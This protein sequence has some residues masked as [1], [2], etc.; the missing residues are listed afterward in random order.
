[1]HSTFQA[2]WHVTPRKPHK[3]ISSRGRKLPNAPASSHLLQPLAPAKRQCGDSFG[4]SSSAMEERPC[5]RSQGDPCFDPTDSG[6]TPKKTTK[7]D[8]NRSEWIHGF[9]SS[10]SHIL[11]RFCCHK[12]Y[13]YIKV[14]GLGRN[15]WKVLYKSSLRSLSD[16]CTRTSHLKATIGMTTYVAKKNCLHCLIHS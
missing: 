16:F 2:K 12:K 13:I 11:L 10:S 1:M 6:D 7:D 5:S 3:K 14:L 8:V 4:Q 15:P 9:D